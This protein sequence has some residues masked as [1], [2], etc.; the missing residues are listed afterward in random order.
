LAEN[1]RLEVKGAYV[2]YQ[3]NL[4]QLGTQKTNMELTQGVY[5]RIKYKFDQGVS[6]SLDLLSAENELQQAQNNYID[7]LLNTLMSRVD[8]EKAMG[9]TLGAQP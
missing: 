6:S 8:L 3:N 4:A 2:Q 1:I 9:R 5:D 7:A